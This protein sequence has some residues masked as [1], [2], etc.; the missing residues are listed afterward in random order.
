MACTGCRI[1]NSRFFVKHKSRSNIFAFGK[2]WALLGTNRHNSGTRRAPKSLHEFSKCEKS[3]R[4]FPVPSLCLNLAPPPVN[5]PPA[6]REYTI[7]S[8]TPLK[9][10]SSRRTSTLELAGQPAYNPQTT[11]S[12]EK[13]DP[14]CISHRNPTSRFRKSFNQACNSWGTPFAPI[15]CRMP[16]RGASFRI[17]PARYSTERIS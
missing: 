13:V 5:G 1:A 6:D 15:V 8:D 2:I 11:G 3:S 4:R 10:V 14:C 7:E 16:K 17:E 9:Q 12:P